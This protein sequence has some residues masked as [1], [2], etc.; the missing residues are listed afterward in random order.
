MGF[1]DAE[2]EQE[3]SHPEVGLTGSHSADVRG[4]TMPSSGYRHALQG[5]GYLAAAGSLG[6]GSL[7]GA[8]MGALGV[9][10][11]GM[12]DMVLNP[13]GNLAQTKVDTTWLSNARNNDMFEQ[14][15]FRRGRYDFRKNSGIGGS[16]IARVASR[17]GTAVANAGPEAPLPWLRYQTLRTPLIDSRSNIGRY[18]RRMADEVTFGKWDPRSRRDVAGDVLNDLQDKFILEKRNFDDPWGM[19]TG[20]S[21]GANPLTRPL[22]IAINPI[23]RAL[24]HPG[25]EAYRRRSNLMA[26][27]ERQ[28]LTRALEDPRARKELAMIL[29]PEALVAGGGVSGAALSTLA[30][31]GLDGGEPHVPADIVPKTSAPR[32]VSAYQLGL[33]YGLV[34]AAEAFEVAQA[35]HVALVPRS[36]IKTSGKIVLSSPL[37]KEASYSAV[38]REMAN[39]PPF[40]VPGLEGGGALAGMWK[41]RPTWAGGPTTS[42]RILD[43]LKDLVV[44]DELV[45]NASGV[46]IGRKKT[47]LPGMTGKLLRIPVALGGLVALNAGVRAY[48][49]RKHRSTSDERFEQALNVL[50]T[51]DGFNREFSDLIDPNTEEGQMVLPRVREGFDIIDRYAP[52]VAAD[53]KLAAQFTESFVRGVGGDGVMTPD[54]YSQRVESAIALQNSIDKRKDTTIFGSFGSM[55]G[56]LVNPE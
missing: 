36:K 11:P 38:F 5:A 20:W 6:R 50:R 2:L 55:L 49:D 53:P 56:Q 18:A 27:G 43:G 12:A 17:L 30:D 32:Q 3:L 25:K 29:G 31:W 14:P 9:G 33:V 8:G 4:Q 47:L 24:G 13:A 34:G 51:D 39:K 48:Q 28:G 22:D 46:P 52:T 19:E 23:A 45:M 40:P 54:Q 1:I 26:Y 10:W 16:L 21:M 44:R 35:G 42:K 41:N 15:T 7:L 37:Q